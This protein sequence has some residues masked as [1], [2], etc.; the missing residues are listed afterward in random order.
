[1]KNI[2]KK[3]Y[4]KVILKNI[5]LVIFSILLA[6][7]MIEIVYGLYH[8]SSYKH[9]KWAKHK[10]SK[11]DIYMDYKNSG[12]DVVVSVHP[13]SF[14][15]KIN[16]EDKIHPLSGI[17]NKSTIHCNESGYWKIYKSDRYGFNNPDK[18][19]DKLHFDFVLIGDSFTLG[20]CVHEKDTIAGQLRNKTEVLNLGYSGNGPLLEYATLREY[21]KH[22]EAKNVLWLYYE[23]DLKNFQLELSNKVLFNYLAD[24]NFTQD[25]INRQ[26]EIDYIVSNALLQALKKYQIEKNVLFRLEEFNFKRVLLLS[27]IRHRLSLMFKINLENISLISLKEGESNYPDEFSELLVQANN[28]VIK[29]NSKLYFVYLPAYP[30]I[31]NSTTDRQRLQDYKK[32]INLVEELNIPIIDTY[33]D[34]FS[35]RPDPKSLFTLPKASSH[36]NVEGYRLVVKTILDKM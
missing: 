27:Y 8:I 3:S 24:I 20:T 30:G 7:Y 29:N 12:K 4:S 21:F 11:Y 9:K 31:Y 13:A 34:L 23:N 10:R 18:E 1:M 14:I 2:K 5:S 26:K 17:S 36:Y 16:N 25:L 22:I 33:K 32:V 19:W 35:N 6:I 28:L 15:S